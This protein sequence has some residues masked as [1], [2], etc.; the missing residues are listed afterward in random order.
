MHTHTG[1]IPSFTRIETGKICFKSL[2]IRIT[3]SL[4]M[5]DCTD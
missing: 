2:V 3:Q 1:Y 5:L 4:A